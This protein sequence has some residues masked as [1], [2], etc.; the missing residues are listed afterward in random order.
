MCNSFST[1]EAILIFFSVEN[2][3]FEGG[4]NKTVDELF[5]G[6]LKNSCAFDNNLIFFEILY[7]FLKY[8]A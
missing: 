3:Y 8:K 7:N 1:F 4:K 6:I 2:R 5:S